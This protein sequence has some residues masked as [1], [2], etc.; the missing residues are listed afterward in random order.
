MIKDTKSIKLAGPS[1]SL[2][3]D[4]NGNPY[5]STMPYGIIVE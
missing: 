2:K 1:V 3:P 5:V 4:P